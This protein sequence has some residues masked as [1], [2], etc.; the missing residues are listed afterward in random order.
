MLGEAG[1]EK[2]QEP[3]SATDNNQ[4][5]EGHQSRSQTQ[6][7]SFAEQS[8]DLDSDLFASPTSLPPSQ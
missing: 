3:C 6:E 7:G 4:T 5:G 8:V 1:A 2:T